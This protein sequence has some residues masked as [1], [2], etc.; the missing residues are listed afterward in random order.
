MRVFVA[1][2]TRR[3][4]H[5]AR[6]Q[7]VERGHEVVGTLPLAGEGRA[8]CATLGAEPVVLDLLD[9]RRRAARPSRRRGRTRSSTRRPRSPALSDLK[10]F[11]RS[12]APTNRLRTE[13][14]DNLLAAAREAGVRRFVAQSFAGWPYAR[15]GGPVKTEEDPLDPTPAPAMRETLAAIRHLEQT[16]RRRGRRRAPLRR[17]LRRPGRRAARARP[18]APLPDRRRRRRH[19]VVRPPRRRGRGDRARARARRAGRLQRR[20]R[21]AGA[22]ARVA[23]RR[24]PTAIGAKPPRRVPALARAARS[25]ARPASC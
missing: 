3:D 15:E 13:G 22:G 11:D 5:A 2:A 10:H 9:P 17:P 7:L 24:W 21:R 19:L 12:F 20:R 25:P 14:T 18:Q 4:R 23:A 6:P 8:G 1:G 16:R